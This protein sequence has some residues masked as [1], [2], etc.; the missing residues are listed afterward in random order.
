MLKLKPLLTLIS[1]VRSRFQL[2]SLKLSFL[3]GIFFY[4]E[5]L[6][7]DCLL[8]NNLTWL[9][10]VKEKSCS[11]VF[12]QEMLTTVCYVAPELGLFPKSALQ[13]IFGHKQLQQIRFSECM[14][15]AAS[16]ISILTTHRI[17]HPKPHLPIL[18]YQTC[19]KGLCAFNL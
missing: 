14:Q 10:E 1:T 12:W 16:S 13:H 18:H 8:H 7:E 9:L 15:P 3:R 2:Q 5:L 19:S 17:T 11:L 4:S 6:F